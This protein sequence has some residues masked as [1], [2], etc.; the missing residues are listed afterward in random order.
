[1]KSVI[2]NANRSQIHNQPVVRSVQMPKP[3][4]C[5]TATKIQQSPL[6]QKVAFED[7]DCDDSSSSEDEGTPL[8]RYQ[9]RNGS[10]YTLPIKPPRKNLSKTQQTSQ[11]DGNTFNEKKALFEQLTQPDI[12]SSNIQTNSEEQLRINHFKSNIPLPPPPPPPL[13][14][15]KSNHPPP[16]PPK[17]SPKKFVPN[18]PIRKNSANNNFAYNPMMYEHEGSK[19]IWT[20]TGPTIAVPT[21]ILAGMKFKP[22][23]FMDKE[24][25]F[26]ENIYSVPCSNEEEEEV[27]QLA[28]PTAILAGLTPPIPP[29]RVESAR[30]GNLRKHSFIY[31][32]VDSILEIEGDTRVI[33]SANKTE[34]I[35]S[36]VSIESAPE[37]VVA[38]LGRFARIKNFFRW[39]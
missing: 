12:I 35:G 16:T 38:N 5:S 28:I 21:A 25:S 15:P 11:T 19:T 32:S 10:I 7:Q 30:C 24:N 34:R 39:K 26:E 13:P 1:M 17:P 9:S 31:D 22:F 14:P 37:V 2:G 20:P 6:K 23:G 8:I 27:P 33:Y 29:V 4:T 36:P 3:I 18:E